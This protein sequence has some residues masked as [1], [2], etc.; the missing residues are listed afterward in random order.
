LYNMKSCLVEF[1]SIDM[2]GSSV[3]HGVAAATP[4]YNP[5]FY[6]LI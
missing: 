5:I 6:L 2:G 4:D 1:N 3:R